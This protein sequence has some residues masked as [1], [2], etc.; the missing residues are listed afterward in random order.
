MLRVGSRYTFTCQIAIVQTILLVLNWLFIGS[1]LQMLSLIK[2]TRHNIEQVFICSVLIL[3]FSL[4]YFI[5]WNTVLHY[6]G[7]VRRERNIR[8]GTVTTLMVDNVFVLLT[9]NITPSKMIRGLH[10]TLSCV[11]MYSLLFTFWLL[12][13]TVYLC[14]PS[15]IIGIFSILVSWLSVHIVVAANYTAL[16]SKLR[17]TLYHGIN[18]FPFTSRKQFSAWQTQTNTIK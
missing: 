10:Q 7:C 17:V 18:R 16:L 9:N 4:L 13:L 15:L 2:T 6:L 5:R 8:N 14:V 1:L 12:C 3:C 11:L